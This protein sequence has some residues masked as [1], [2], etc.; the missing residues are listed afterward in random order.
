MFKVL[1]SNG[2]CA[3][4]HDT[5]NL[6]CGC[7]CARMLACVCVC[8]HDHTGLNFMWY[9]EA[10]NYLA[11]LY[12]HV[13]VFVRKQKLC[14]LFTWEMLYRLQCSFLLWLTVDV[15]VWYNFTESDWRCW[16]NSGWYRWYNL[17]AWQVL[18]PCQ[19][20]LSPTREACRLLPYSFKVSCC[21]SLLCVNVK[22]YLFWRK[23]FGNK[24]WNMGIKAN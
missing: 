21:S 8:I 3:G 16:E 18:P 2:C 5:K 4:L 9:A 22:F 19:S 1:V 11:I 15:M 7:V 10:S 14:E 12:R 13:L 24:N 20:I 17:S 6:K 23:A